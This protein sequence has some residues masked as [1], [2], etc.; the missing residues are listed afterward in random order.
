M[1]LY[2]KLLSMLCLI[3]KMKFN[4]LIL[5]Y[6]YNRESTHGLVE[7]VKTFSDKKRKPSKNFES[8]LAKNLRL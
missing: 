2:R 6:L 7:L 1:G 8:S 4:M 3:L 5:R